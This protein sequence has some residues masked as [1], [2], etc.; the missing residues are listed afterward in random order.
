[1]RARDASVRATR[2]ATTDG[3]ERVAVDRDAW[4]FLNRVRFRGDG[5]GDGGW[6]TGDVCEGFCVLSR[7]RRGGVAAASRRR[8]GGVASASRRRRGGVGTSTELKRHATFRNV[9]SVD[10]RQGCLVYGYTVY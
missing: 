6:A 2:R 4:G 3:I 5:D 1:V 9:A 10:G 8:R 7:R